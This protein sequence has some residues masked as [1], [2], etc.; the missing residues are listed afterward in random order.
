VFD[1]AAEWMQSFV[2]WVSAWPFLPPDSILTFEFNVRALL[3]VVLVSL[4]CGAVGSLIVGN[5]MAFFSDALA[6][7]AFA[8]VALGLVICLAIG[9]DQAVFRQQLILILVLF[10]IAIGLLIAYV[11]EATDL[12]SDTIIGV[13]YAGAIGL[14][15]AFL[16]MLAGRQ[17][18][19][20]ES[21]LFGDPTLVTP[22]E[23]VWL[24]L[25]AI[26]TVLF[27]WLFYNPL[28]LASANPSLA[29]S[30]QVR[31]RLHRY[32]FII[33]L[34][35]MV[36]LSLMIVGTLLINGMLIVPAAAAANVARNLRQMFWFSVGLAVSVGVCGY[37]LSWEIG[38]RFP[39]A[40]GTSGTIVV[41]A[42]LV[43]IVCALVGPRLRARPRPATE[44]AE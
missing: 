15:A 8:G 31:I 11:R 39:N 3:A 27:L 36:N 33:L 25:L 6:H 41:L 24:V 10:G 2:L 44:P 4:V 21:F 40:V 26:G 14:G 29:R 35:L 32:L 19:N 12:A 5:R 30:R 18:F 37:L 38:N 7:C 23:L 34:G 42:V 43:F 20:I 13:F 9:A 1:A 16:K 17:F 28:V 22:L